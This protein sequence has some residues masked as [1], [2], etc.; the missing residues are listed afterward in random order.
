MS[1]HSKWATIKNQ[2]ASTDSKRGAIFTKLARNITIATREKGGDPEMNANLR[3]AIDKAKQFNMPKDNIERAIKR[4]TGEL[5]GANIEEITYE[6]YGPDGVAL[7]IKCLTDN[8]N[9][10]VSNVR[11][12]LSKHNGSLGET[13]SVLWMFDE[14]GVVRFYE[15]QLVEKNINLDEL[16]LI[17]I[18]AGADD[19]K[20]E[21]GEFVIYTKSQDMQNV[22][23]IAED[24]GIVI[25]TA[26]LEWIA[27][28]EINIKD[29][30]SEK[31]ERLLRALDDDEDVQEVYSN[32]KFT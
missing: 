5:E 6:A 15:N 1:G 3:T 22:K 7:I 4:G 29:E 10:T 12:I 16:E 21:G 25:D 24:R 14:K 17:I 13:N 11:H 20:K 27:K 2:K 26:Q 31:I 32:I 8:R 9:R 30:S 23:N 19:I 28:N 18:D